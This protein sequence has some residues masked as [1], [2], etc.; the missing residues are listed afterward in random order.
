[1]FAGR[2]LALGGKDA[3]DKLLASVE[4]LSLVAGQGWQ[5]QPAPMF[6]ADAGFGFTSVT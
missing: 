2:L 6:K 1:M 5:T 3:G 4:M